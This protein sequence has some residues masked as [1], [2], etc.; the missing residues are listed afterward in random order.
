[1]SLQQGRRG[2]FLGLLLGPSI[3]V[4]A[5]ELLSGCLKPQLGF[6]LQLCATIF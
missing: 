3:W 2:V 6:E 5:N 1:M 4:V